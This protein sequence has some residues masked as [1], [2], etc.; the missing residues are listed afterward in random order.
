MLNNCLHAVTTRLEE[1]VV[2]ERE[3]AVPEVATAATEL[4]AKMVTLQDA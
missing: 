2:A 3:R 4:E 1:V